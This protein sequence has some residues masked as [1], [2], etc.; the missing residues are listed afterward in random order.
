[1]RINR[2]RT[3]VGRVFFQRCFYLFVAV[4]ALVMAVLLLEPSRHGRLIINAINLFVL[5]AAVA[6]VG[7]TTLSFVIAVL[8]AAPAL[9][10]Q[11]LA[12][13]EADAA[14]LVRSWAFGALLYAVT[15]GYQLHYVFQRDVMT[16]EALWRC[17]RISHAWRAV[18]LSLRDR[19]PLPA[20]LVLVRRRGRIADVR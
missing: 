9:L 13:N 4:L 18:G 15:I 7:R 20:G 19:E 10:F 16:S 1:M 17:G 14:F 8:L 6:A 11:M 3:T 5:V 12:I 2:V